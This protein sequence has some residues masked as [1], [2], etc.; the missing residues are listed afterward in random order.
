MEMSVF[1]DAEVS[2]MGD[3]GERSVVGFSFGRSC[4]DIFWIESIVVITARIFFLEAKTFAADVMIFISTEDREMGFFRVLW[5]KMRD[6][7]RESRRE[8]YLKH[9]T[10]VAGGAGEFRAKIL[11]KITG[12][13]NWRFWSCQLSF[14]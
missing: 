5:M 13:H 14:Y 9:E 11:L 7:G 3:L 12:T 1:V 10:C 8:S 2:G 4:R 6:L